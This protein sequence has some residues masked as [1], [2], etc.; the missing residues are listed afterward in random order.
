MSI[1]QKP[2][3]EK[4]LDKSWFFLQKALLWFTQLCPTL[5][6]PMGCST[7]GF[8]P[9]TIPWS[10]LKSMSTESVMPS[11]HLIL[12][13][14]LFRLPSIF[15]S[16]KVFPNELALCIKWP[17]YWSFSFSFNLSN[18]Y[19]GLISFRIDYFDLLSPWSP[20]DSQYSSFFI[21]E[22]TLK[23][24]LPWNLI[25]AEIRAGQRGMGAHSTKI[26][27]KPDWGGFSKTG[28]IT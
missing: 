11:N 13:H 23:K 21:M 4:C 16:I 12:R 7:P 10:L 22:H 14:P 27:G 18:E 24:K 9:S 26:L 25:Q 19:S 17:K 5:C 28:F 1:G 2:Q 8:P 3:D 20:R 6:D 15:S